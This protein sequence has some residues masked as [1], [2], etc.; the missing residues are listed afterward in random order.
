MNQWARIIIL[1][2]MAALVHGCRM[3][4]RTGPPHPPALDPVEVSDKQPTYYPGSHEC[5]E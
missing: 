3:T 2:G 4:Y 5:R 1:V